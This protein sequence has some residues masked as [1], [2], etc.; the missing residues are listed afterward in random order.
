MIILFCAKCL[1]LFLNE[2]MSILLNKIDNPL[3]AHNHETRA[4][5]NNELVFPRYSKSKCQNGLIFC[6]IKL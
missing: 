1:G 6:G 5:V 4:G 2:N 3:I